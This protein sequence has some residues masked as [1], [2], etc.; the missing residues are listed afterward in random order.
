MI[1]SL[2]SSTIVGCIITVLLVVP[3]IIAA[4]GG[5]GSIKEK[6][7][8]IISLAFE[9][10]KKTLTYLGVIVAIISLFSIISAV[11]KN[12]V[13]KEIEKE[14]TDSVSSVY[15]CENAI[16]YNLKN[17]EISVDDID[18]FNG[19]IRAHITVNCQAEAGGLYEKENLC[20]D[21]MDAFPSSVYTSKYGSVKVKDLL[22]FDTDNDTYGVSIY[23]N[24]YQVFIHGHSFS[25]HEEDEAISRKVHRENEFE[26][27]YNQYSEYY[28]VFG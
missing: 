25:E 10:K 23:V 24:D 21:I 3:G 11:N 15:T 8:N 9:H 26:S 4:F 18:K 2:Y 19:E 6:I 14:L 28:A 16:E 17:I 22:Y 27:K 5:F 13:L 1:D 12:A 7:S 20:D